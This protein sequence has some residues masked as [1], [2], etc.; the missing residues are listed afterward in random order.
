MSDHT[1]GRIRLTL[2]NLLAA[3]AACGLMAVIVPASL[4]K[5][6]QHMEP[7][8][9]ANNLRVCHQGWNVY[10]SDYDGVWMAPWDR[11]NTWPGVEYS[12]VQQWPYT[13]VHFVTGGGIPLGETVYMAGAYGGEWYGPDGRHGYPPE[14]CNDPLDAPQLQCATTAAEGNDLNV[15]WWRAT[16]YSYAIMG[17][18]LIEGTWRYDMRYYPKPGLMTH[19]ASTLLLMD[20]S[21]IIGEPYP[22]AW[23]ICDGWYT[24]PHD[25]TSNYLMCDGHVER[26]ADEQANCQMWESLWTPDPPADGGTN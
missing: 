20:L 4:V 5:L 16:S 15:I 21:G 2:G 9:C 23:C 24:D 6:K 25:G 3:V 10:S 18:R 11:E 19:P 22:A 8:T 7:V 1:N 12:W 13:M 26:L 17:G 14:Y